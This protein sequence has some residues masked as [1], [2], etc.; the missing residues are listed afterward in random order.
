MTSP[1]RFN[2]SSAAATAAATA[3]PD[4]PAL[5]DPLSPPAPAP[6]QVACGLCG[7][8]FA[9]AAETMGCPR[10]PMA[11]GCAIL[12]CPRCGYEFVTESRIVN[13]FR[14]LFSR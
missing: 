10:C 3:T 1:V 14:R 4:A 2:P 5:P 9:P 12:C 8:R 6:R 13:F 11:R 7:H